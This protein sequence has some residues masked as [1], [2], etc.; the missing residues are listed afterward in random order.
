MPELVWRTMVHWHHDIRST[1]SRDPSLECAYVSLK[2][3]FQNV[4]TSGGQ[5]EAVTTYVYLKCAANSAAVSPV[6]EMISLISP[7]KVWVRIYEGVPRQS[8]RFLRVDVTPRLNPHLVYGSTRKFSVLAR[9]QINRTELACNWVP[10]VNWLD[11]VQTSELCFGEDSWQ[12]CIGSH[13][14]QGVV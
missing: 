1:T 10:G 6:F 2:P 5:A 14:N 11:P 12:K 3:S 4:S 13:S 7:G 8:R 9:V